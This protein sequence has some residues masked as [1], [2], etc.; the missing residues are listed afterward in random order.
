MLY[1]QRSGPVSRYL[2][3]LKYL[4]GH[5]F[6]TL[7]VFAPF[8]ASSAAS[9]ELAR[10]FP[11]SPVAVQV[12]ELRQYLD[13]HPDIQN[14]L[15]LSLTTPCLNG[16][17]PAVS[18]VQ[19]LYDML[20]D[21]P[22]SILQRRRIPFAPMSCT[23]EKVSGV[24]STPAASPALFPL[25]MSYFRSFRDYMG[26]PESLA[27]VNDWLDAPEVHIQDFIVPAGGFTSFNDFFGRQLKPGVRPIASPHDDDVVTSPNDGSTKVQHTSVSSRTKLQAKGD[28]LNISAIFG[29][30]PLAS[31]FIG[32]TVLES[33]LHEYSYHHFHAPVSGTVVQAALFPEVTDVDTGSQHPW[34]TESYNHHRGAYIIYNPRLGYVGMVPVGILRISHITLLAETGTHVEKGQE[35]GHFAFGGSTILLFFEP[36]AITT[37]SPESRTKTEKYRWGKQLA[38]Q[39]CRR[40]AISLS[41]LNLTGAIKLPNYNRNALRDSE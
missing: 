29:N 25:M 30:H 10:A 11:P 22:G 21:M 27:Y 41:C 37:H 28:I 33:T 26:R 9:A 1:A 6:L 14:Q 24:R 20:L 8:S 18:S 5:V 17:A 16:T 3:L 35:L 4:P 23:I 36:G 38:G 13:S 15:A 39:N 12:S 34:S 19:G 7:L 31:H 2:S 32:G 40:R